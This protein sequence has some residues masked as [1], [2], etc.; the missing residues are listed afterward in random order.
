MDPDANESSTLYK[1]LIDEKNTILKG[2]DKGE[3]LPEGKEKRKHEI[4]ILQVNNLWTE[5][6]QIQN[7]D[8]IPRF[9]QN[10]DVLIPNDTLGTRCKIVIFGH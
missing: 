6:S 2:N 3:L 5:L 7:S 9:H 8:K 4:A 1:Q 10:I